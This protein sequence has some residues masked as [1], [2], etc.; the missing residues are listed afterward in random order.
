MPSSLPL[1]IVA[2]VLGGCGDVRDTPDGAPPP[3][4]VARPA[5]RATGVVSLPRRLPAGM[6]LEGRVPPGSQVSING[7]PLPVPANGRLH[8]TV[9]AGLPA[10]QVRVQRP[11]GRVL[12]QQV[13][14]EHSPQ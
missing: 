2:T 3:L 7:Q 4:E 1:L 5:G 9:P 14:I 8:W 11:D 6:P 12:V 13:R 10:L